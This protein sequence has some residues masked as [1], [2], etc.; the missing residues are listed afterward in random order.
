MDKSF[1]KFELQRK[2]DDEL[3]ML[4]S[5]CKEVHASEI[6][7]IPKLFYIDAVG[8]FICPGVAVA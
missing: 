1:N 5:I 6:G 3:S 2:W 4:L 7:R 8:L